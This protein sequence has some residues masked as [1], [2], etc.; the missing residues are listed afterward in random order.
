MGIIRFGLPFDK[1]LFLAK[2][3]KLDVFIESGTYMGETCREAQ[4]YFE[5]VF[6]IE[7]SEQM[8]E[9]AKIN[10][11][12]SCLIFLLKG[13]T[14]DH[15]G[16]LL[17]NND[18]ILFWLDAH[19][20]GGQTYGESDECPLLEELGIIFTN[21]KHCAILIDDARLFLSPPP[22]PHVAMNWPSIRDIANVTPK[23]YELTIYEDVVY[24]YPMEIKLAF[25]NLIQDEVT[26]SWL[27]SQKNVSYIERV[28]QYFRSALRN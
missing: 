26:K 15:L 1:A 23:N 6:T 27:I 3:L 19:W 14:R 16:P 22:R 12:D 18:N 13:D 11:A 2:N 7:K 4:K 17:V 8:Y 24:I 25:T 5:K 21:K 20:S 28:K 9:Q 10:L